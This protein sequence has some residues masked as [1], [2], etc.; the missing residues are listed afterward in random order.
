MSS[1]YVFAQMVFAVVI[2]KNTL[3]KVKALQKDGER[4]SNGVGKSLDKETLLLYR[5]TKTHQDEQKKSRILDQNLDLI[6]SIHIAGA[7]AICVHQTKSHKR[8]SQNWWQYVKG[9]NR[10]ATR[11]ASRIALS[12]SRR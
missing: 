7:A 12:I 11:L 4:R 6:T 2:D 9:C 1:I 8:L 5:L 3:E 10:P